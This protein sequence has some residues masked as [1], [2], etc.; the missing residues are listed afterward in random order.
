MFRKQKEIELFGRKLIMTDRLAVDVIK[1][2]NEREKAGEVDTMQNL[3][4]LA[5]AISDSLKSN[6]A[7]FWQRLRKITSPQYLL[8]NCSISELVALNNILYELENVIPADDSKKK[9]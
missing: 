7:P 6:K 9:T 2:D 1:L 5:V 8:Y 3:L 4:F